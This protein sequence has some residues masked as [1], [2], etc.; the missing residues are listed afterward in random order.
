M[1]T[2]DPVVLA[3]RKTKVIVQDLRYMLDMVHFL[4][5]DLDPNDQEELT[6]C[7]E[8]IRHLHVMLSELCQE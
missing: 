7:N 4:S 2:T 6:E 5:E 1:P 3:A 8:Y